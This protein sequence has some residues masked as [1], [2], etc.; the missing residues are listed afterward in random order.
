LLGFLTARTGYAIE[1]RYAEA[2]REDG[3]VT[4][5]M[6]YAGAAP[7]AP[8]TPLAVISHGAGGSEEGY[9]YLAEAMAKLGFRTMVMGH[10]ESGV[11]AL[12]TG[13]AADG[14]TAGLRA[15]VADPH[16]ETARLMDVGATL[17]LAEARCTSP[18]RILLGH[19]MGAETVMLEAGARNKIGIASP[20]AG[21]DRFSAYVALSP[22]GPG[23][24]FPEHAWS[25]I[26]RPLLTI[27]GTRD[28]S[29][30]GP[31]AT[32]EIPWQELPGAVGQCQWLAVI[33][34][35]THMNLAG[36]GLGHREAEARVV[37]TLE[38]FVAGVKRRDCSQ[39]RP[40]A[41]V[42]IRRK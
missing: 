38:A 39:P 1:A 22:E 16:A 24:V 14:M 35:A 9:R 23:L 40:I 31:P 10:R 13:I 20:P 37:A 29:L 32:R 17:R 21:R 42:S 15:L 8:C 19:S 11:N 26:Q 27:A 2:P 28:Q 6:I 30:T 41:G 25:S 7:D 12:R 33:D 3:G 36:R 18:F 34:D 4:P 5:L